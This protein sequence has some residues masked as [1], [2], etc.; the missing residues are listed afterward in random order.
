MFLSIILSFC[1]ILES[2][3]TTV[4]TIGEDENT[5]ETIGEDE[6]TLETI[7]E[8]ENT[9]ETIGEDENTLET[10][11]EDENTLE[12]IGED[13]ALFSD[14]EVDVFICG[15][16]EVNS[17]LKTALVSSGEDERNTLISSG[18]DLKNTLDS[19]GGDLSTQPLFHRRKR[20]KLRHIVISSKFNLP[21]LA[22]TT[23]KTVEDE[24]ALLNRVVSAPS[25]CC[26]RRADVKKLRE[27][28]RLF[29]KRYIE[30]YDDNFD[31]DNFEYDHSGK[32][33]SDLIEDVDS[34][35]YEMESEDIPTDSGPTRPLSFNRQGDVTPL[36][37]SS[38]SSS[39]IRPQVSPRSVSLIPLEKP[40][41][42]VT[43]TAPATTNVTILTTSPK[44]GQPQLSDPIPLQIP[45]SFN[46]SIRPKVSNFNSSEPDSLYFVYK[47]YLFA[48]FFGI[49]GFFALVALVGSIRKTYF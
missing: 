33:G 26:L 27:L 11:G 6:N 1:L 16:P 12:T 15:N 18:E 14:P 7:G 35:D 40:T 9:L 47:P 29:G 8:D 46:G 28:N 32:E 21:V 5:L 4:Q 43:Q 44:V 2:D 17:D 48:F 38:R 36:V 31:D 19:G 30:E 39:P 37:N 3:E 45:Q 41:L 49:F 10:I 22:R 24:D 42:T 25:L 13:V 20:C 23:E 34:V